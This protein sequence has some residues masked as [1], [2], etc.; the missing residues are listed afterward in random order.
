MELFENIKQEFSE[1]D[2]LMIEKMI[3]SHSKIVIAAF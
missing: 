2:G 1:K 3:Y